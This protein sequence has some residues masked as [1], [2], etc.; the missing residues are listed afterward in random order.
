MSSVCTVSETSADKGDAAHPQ[1]EHGINS[2]NNFGHVVPGYNAQNNLSAENL[3]ER[4]LGTANS[5]K[6]PVVKKVIKGLNEA[7]DLIKNSEMYGLKEVFIKNF[8]IGID[9]NS[10]AIL[11]ELI[12]ETGRETFDRSGNFDYFNK[13]LHLLGAFSFPDLKANAVKLI[14]VQIQYFSKEQRKKLLNGLKEQLKAFPE[15][16]RAY[17]VKLIAEQI[18]HIPFG[19]R[20]ELLG[21]LLNFLE[22]FFAAIAKDENPLANALKVISEQVQCI[23]D[24]Q[25]GELLGEL[26]HFSRRSFRC[27]KFK[28]YALGAIARQVQHLPPGQRNE[29]L[30]RLLYS[31]GVFEDERPRAWAL[32]AIAGQI[33]YF[34]AD[35]CCALRNFLNSSQSCKLLNYLMLHIKTLGSAESKVEVLKTVAGQIGHL[36]KDQRKELLSALLKL[37]KNVQK[38]DLANVLKIIAGQVGYFSEDQRKELLN[39]LLNSAKKITDEKSRAEALEAIAGQIQYFVPDKHSTLLSILF[40]GQRCKLLKKLLESM[41]GMGHRT[42][43]LKSVGAQIGCLSL[44][45]Y[46]ELPKKFLDFAKNTDSKVPQKTEQATLFPDNSS[47]KSLSDAL[48]SAE[49]INGEECRADVLAAIAGQIGRLS[50]EK[51]NRLLDLA[52]K[53]NEE[54]YRVD[55]LVAIAGQFERLSLEQFLGL[56]KLTNRIESEE[57][58]ANVLVATAEQIR[59]SPASDLRDRAPNGLIKLAAKIRNEEYR[60]NVLAAIAGQFE[61]LSLEQFSVFLKL[62]KGIKD[63]ECRVN[64]LLPITKKLENLTPEQRK[65]LLNELLCLEKSID[66]PESRANVLMF[67][68][69]TEYP[70]SKFSPNLPPEKRSLLLGELLNLARN[71][72]DEERRTKMLETIIEQIQCLPLDQRSESLGRLPDL[73]KNISNAERRAKMLETV[74]GQIQDLGENERGKLLD[75]LRKLANGIKGENSRE[76][77]LNA[78][79]Q[80][81]KNSV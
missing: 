7:R 81:P 72:G 74:A 68:V 37:M 31:E 34:V 54:E 62:T 70:P 41:K 44:D 16:G 39:E 78:I 12:A 14:A 50:P 1:N 3:S 80:L 24:E 32:E 69:Q 46:N 60:A 75:K 73:V 53:I 2:H 43:V 52:A 30:R 59:R 64:A 56:L 61:R 71:I 47:D 21:E 4:K 13:L 42:E 55:V 26:L 49:N 5:A 6:G 11:A 9:H 79:K 25:R 40:P 76:F 36:S 15:D 27:E 18:Q 19:Q 48:D 65:E 17:A 57:H 63:E 67:F 35:N 45:Q 38:S 10:N 8:A 33:K 77:L 23:P 28:A 29:L 66:D 51:R 22:N 58:R 20:R